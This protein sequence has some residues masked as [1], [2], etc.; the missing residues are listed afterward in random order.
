MT[1]QTT[2]PETGCIYF[3]KKPIGISPCILGNNSRGQ[4][5]PGL[6]VLPLL[7][8]RKAAGPHDRLGAEG[9]RCDGLG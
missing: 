5:D 3:N 8:L 6:N 9:W 2:K 7:R 4:R 1:P